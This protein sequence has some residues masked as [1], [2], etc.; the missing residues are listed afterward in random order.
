MRSDPD[1]VQGHQKNG[2]TIPVHAP[3]NLM[4]RGSAT[5]PTRHVYWLLILSGIAIPAIEM[6]T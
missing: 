3:R 5:L 2:S 4:A 6:D 1:L